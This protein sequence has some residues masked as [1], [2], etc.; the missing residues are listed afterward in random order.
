M[1]AS[2]PAEQSRPTL[3]FLTKEA[4]RLSLEGFA[5]GAACE[6]CPPLP[7]LAKRYGG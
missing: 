3:T 2:G 7:D 6:G 5:Q 1:V 4:V